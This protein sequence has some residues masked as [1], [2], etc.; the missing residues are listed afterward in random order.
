MH[1]KIANAKVIE[2]PSAQK[3]YWKMGIHEQWKMKVE[4][5]RTSSDLFKA[6]IEPKKAA[7]EGEG[8]Q[9]P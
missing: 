6:K 9:T 3:R 5:W 8:N 4:K 7:F 1:I 2:Q